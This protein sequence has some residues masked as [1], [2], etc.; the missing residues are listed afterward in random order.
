MPAIRRT[1]IERGLPDSGATPADGAGR[2]LREARLLKPGIHSHAASGLKSTR[3][4]DDVGEDLARLR[5]LQVPD[6]T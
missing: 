1:G 4:A 6:R 5:G 2:R 3:L